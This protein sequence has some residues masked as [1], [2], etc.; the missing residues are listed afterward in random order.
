I[1][2][3]IGLVFLVLALY[4]LT[5]KRIIKC[6]TLS[7]LS[8]GFI[9]SSLIILLLGINLHTYHR[10]T[11]EVPIANIQFWQTGP[12]Q[13][14]AVLSHADGINEQSYMINGDEW[15]IDAR[16]LKWNPTAILAGLDSRYRLER[17]SGRYRNIEQERYDQRS[18][19]DL[20]A[21]P[22]LEL[23]PLLIRLQNYLDWIDAYYG[24]SVY[25]PMAD[26]AAYQIVLTQSGI[27][28][29]PDNEQARHAIAS[30]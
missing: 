28:S 17:L 6:C 25:L 10:L 19:F 16:V 27:L 24:N 15:Q 4:T 29:R 21:E 7:V 3:V 11:K 5:K 13:F 1:T 22:G 14:L 30:W 18:V 8:L 23:W 9:C 12:Q 20:S 2:G 26:Q